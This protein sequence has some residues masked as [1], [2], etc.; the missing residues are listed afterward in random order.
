MEVRS[1]SVKSTDKIAVRDYR[2]RDC[3]VKSFPCIWRELIAATRMEKKQKPQQK[4]FLLTW[5]V[6]ILSISAS[7][8]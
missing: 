8:D 4:Y 2:H 7:R 3:T 1:V 5:T 6:R